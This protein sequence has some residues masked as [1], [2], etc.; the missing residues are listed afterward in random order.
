MDSRVDELEHAVLALGKKVE[1]TLSC[2]PQAKAVEGVVTVAQSSPT[3][4]VEG[5]QP[6]LTP[7]VPGSAH[8]EPSPSGTTSGSLDHNESGFGAVYTVAPDQNPAS[9]V[10]KSL[11]SLT[12]ALQTSGA[13]IGEQNV[14]MPSMPNFPYHVVPQYPR[15]ALP[16]FPFS[17]IRWD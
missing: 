14:M 10:K 6:P 7:E 2:L 4:G 16:E 15:S 12:A 8:L 11:Q 5:Y 1:R 13:K 17:A 9:G 3:V